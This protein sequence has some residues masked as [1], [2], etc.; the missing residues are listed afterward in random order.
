[1]IAT[2]ALDEIRS[3]LSHQPW[4][5]EKILLFSV[6]QQDIIPSD[7]E[8][9][10]FFKIY[11]E[12]TLSAVDKRSGYWY[13]NVIGSESGSVWGGRYYAGCLIGE[14]LVI[15]GKVFK[16]EDIDACYRPPID[17]Y[18][19]D[20]IYHRVA[21]IIGVPCKSHVVLNST[22][23]TDQ[24]ERVLAELR[25]LRSCEAFWRDQCG[26]DVWLAVKGGTVVA[27][28]E[29]R[30]V[31]ESIIHSQGIPPPVLYVAPKGQQVTGDIITLVR[32]KERI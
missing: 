27:H 15:V 5:C 21:Q 28:A 1:M 12:L 23:I 6:K 29:D 22:D 2:E 24:G 17:S 25:E 11:R 19:L 20:A 32:K 4:L 31:L 13:G 7:G 9:A 14:L 16:C 8:S 18:F 10:T 26:D 30:S 3:T